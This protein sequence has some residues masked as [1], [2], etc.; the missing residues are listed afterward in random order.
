MKDLGLYYSESL[1]TIIIG[2][3]KPGQYRDRL[4]GRVIGHTKSYEDVYYGFHAFNYGYKYQDWTEGFEYV[5]RYT[6]HTTLK[7]Y[8]DFIK[9]ADF[10]QI[11]AFFKCKDKI[12]EY[13]NSY[14]IS[15]VNGTTKWKERHY[16]KVLV[17]KDLSAT[18]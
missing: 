2:Y 6:T 14:V 5:G 17:N 18:N 15:R 12:V 1:D 10:D 13:M 16:D 3:K 11:K 8:L 9:D 4:V 7:G